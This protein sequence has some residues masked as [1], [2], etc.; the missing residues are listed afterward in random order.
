M[1]SGPAFERPGILVAGVDEIAEQRDA[2]RRW[3]TTESSERAIVHPAADRSAV[4]SDSSNASSTVRS[5]SPSISMMRPLKTLCL[6]PG[7]ER[8]LALLPGHV[9]DGVYQVPQVMPG[10]PSPL[11]TGPAPTRASSIGITPRAAA[12]ATRPDPAG[13]EMPSGNRVCESLPVPTWSGSNIRLSQLWMIPSPGRSTTA[14]RSRMNAGSV[15]WVSMSTG[16]G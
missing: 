13:K 1:A 14:P 15:R 8:E 16:L 6:R 2:R 4:E 3:R 9:R 7:V 11:R 10:L 5:S 12:K